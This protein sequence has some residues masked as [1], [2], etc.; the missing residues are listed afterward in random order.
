MS[1]TTNPLRLP[2]AR[3]EI[4]TGSYSSAWATV[5][6]TD[7]IDDEF[8]E[9]YERLTTDNGQGDKT[10]IWDNETRKTLAILRYSKT[11]DTII[12]KKRL[13]DITE[14]TEEE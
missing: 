13:G 14:D 2:E 4:Q 12:K 7:E 10:R 1:K 3:Y 6:V 11:D 5:A 8:L 9:E